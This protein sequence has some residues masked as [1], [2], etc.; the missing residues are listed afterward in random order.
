MPLS[1]T[2]IWAAAGDPHPAFSDL[3]VE[4]E[5][6][7]VLLSASRGLLTLHE[8]DSHIPLQSSLWLKHA[9]IRV[10]EAAGYRINNA[11]GWTTIEPPLPSLRKDAYDCVSQRI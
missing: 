8:A 7:P 11:H 10:A 2:A 3:G 6:F 5:V 9:A 1:H 4:L